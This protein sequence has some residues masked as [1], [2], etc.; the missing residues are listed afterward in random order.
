MSAHLSAMMLLRAA[1]CNRDTGIPCRTPARCLTTS[2]LAWRFIE[3]RQFLAVREVPTDL[4]CRE[5][6]STVELRADRDRHG[7]HFCLTRPLGR[8]CRQSAAACLRFHR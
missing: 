3:V 4:A 6:T 1:G 7:G 2:R 8:V 5:V